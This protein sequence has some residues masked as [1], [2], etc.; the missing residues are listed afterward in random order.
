[1]ENSNTLNTSDTSNTTVDKNFINSNI[2]YL[3]KSIKNHV[4]NF[5]KIKE[6]IFEII[7]KSFLL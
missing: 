7:N 5:N 3:K 1:M 6:N 4:E 2:D